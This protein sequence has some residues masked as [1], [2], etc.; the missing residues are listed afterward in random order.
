MKKKQK[1]QRSQQPRHSR[2]RRKQD[3][4]RVRKTRAALE[5]RR[6]K[7]RMEKR[8]IQERVDAAEQLLGLE[9]VPLPYSPKPIEARF[10]TRPYWMDSGRHG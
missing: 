5:E 3:P 10:G 6:F 1:R 4:E 8:A 2:Q 9:V 7:E